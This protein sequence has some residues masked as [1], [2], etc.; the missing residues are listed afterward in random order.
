[1]FAT[2]SKHRSVVERCNWKTAVLYELFRCGGY[3][4]VI[5]HVVLLEI[6]GIASYGLNVGTFNSDRSVVFETAP[7]DV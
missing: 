6:G 3:G 1:M 2:V 5:P 4:F 7:I